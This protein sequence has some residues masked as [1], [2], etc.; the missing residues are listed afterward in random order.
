MSD[1]QGLDAVLKECPRS[2]WR[3]TDQSGAFMVSEEGR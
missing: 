3:D 1:E 2:V